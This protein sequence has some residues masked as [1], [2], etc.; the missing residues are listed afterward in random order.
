MSRY[1]ATS[2]SS[3]TDDWPFWYIADTEKGGLNVLPAI[4]RKTTGIAMGSLP[5]TSK[6]HAKILEEE[7]NK[8]GIL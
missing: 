7:A 8:G 2:A 6:Q 3:K 4:Y 1:A 5:F